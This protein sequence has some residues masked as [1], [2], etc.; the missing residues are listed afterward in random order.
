MP[1]RTG[2]PEDIDSI[3]NLIRLCI[4]HM[5]SKNIH[6]WDEI[7]PDKKTIT[8]DIEKH[9]LYVL[10]EDGNLC[11]FIVLNE[12][13]SPE[14]KEINWEF[15][16]K[17]LV[18]H[19]LSVNPSV[20][21]KGFAKKLMQFAYEFAKKQGYESIRLDAFIKNPA[22]IALYTT[23]GYKKA[24]IVVFRKGPFFCFEMRIS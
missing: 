10:E 18:V 4:I 17:T 19:R 1:I 14:Y 8:K 2:S 3:M 21:G 5:E 11:A 24:G 23:L 15:P 9:E 12:F 20:Q 7:Y 16:G 13:Q 22:A 6:Q